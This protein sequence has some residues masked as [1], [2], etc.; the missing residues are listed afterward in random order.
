MYLTNNYPKEQ[1]IISTKV[2]AIQF[3][4][5]YAWSLVLKCFRGMR[6]EAFIKTFVCEFS[7]LVFRSVYRTL[8][9]T[10]IGVL[11]I[12]FFFFKLESLGVF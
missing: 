12:F 6:Y 9:N 7:E 8:Q 10:W 11:K 4:L 1:C 5:D 2:Y 3:H